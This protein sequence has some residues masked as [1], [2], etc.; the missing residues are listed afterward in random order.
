MVAFWSCALV[1]VAC[2]SACPRSIHH[3]SPSDSQSL[4]RPQPLHGDGV[5]LQAEPHPI[6]SPE[7][8]PSSLSAT[9]LRLSPH[10]PAVP[11]PSRHP[12][13]HPETRPARPS[14][15]THRRP[16]LHQAPPPTPQHFL[17]NTKSVPPKAIG[18]VRDS[19]GRHR[20]ALRVSNFR[21]LRGTG[22]EHRDALIAPV[23]LG[24]DVPY[25]LPH[26]PS[27]EN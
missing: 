20:L 3:F 11:T 18:R 12:C 23:D 19:S 15:R 7:T 1:T 17:G 5:L 22:R 16:P 25:E 27:A 26:F 4:F 2:E 8:G 10:F 14:H 21:P 13:H 24:L 6:L 9:T